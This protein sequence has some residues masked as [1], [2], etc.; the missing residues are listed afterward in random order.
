MVRSKYYWQNPK[1]YRAE[2]RSR[3]LKDTETICAQN[4]EYS[5][6]KRIGLMTLIGDKCV[7]C[8]F[9]DVRALDLDH[10][11]GGGTKEYR[12]RFGCNGTMYRYYLVHP[13]E[14]KKDFSDSL[15]K[16]QSHKTSREKRINRC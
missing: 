16:L 11:N 5:Q 3:Y 12:D 9:S 14:A 2:R 8:G 10:I 13:E 4:R 7:R 15:F 1:K 6:K